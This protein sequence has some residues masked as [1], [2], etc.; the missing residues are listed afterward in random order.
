MTCQTRGQEIALFEEYVACKN[1]Q[2]FGRERLELLSIIRTRTV[3]IIE[4]WEAEL[5]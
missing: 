5:K 4:D 1:L 2:N 3:S